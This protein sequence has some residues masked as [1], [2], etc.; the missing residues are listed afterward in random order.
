V[1]NGVLS[2]IQNKQREKGEK[3]CHFQGSFQKGEGGEGGI[4][5]KMER[6]E[7]LSAAL[8]NSIMETV[9]APFSESGTSLERPEHREKGV[10]VSRNPLQEPLGEI[11]TRFRSRASLHRKRK[12]VKKE[13]LC[14]P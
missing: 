6:R 12:G 2:L 13:R 7:S 8:S 11:K 3:V 10:E 5:P 9:Y 1:A 4:A 14:F